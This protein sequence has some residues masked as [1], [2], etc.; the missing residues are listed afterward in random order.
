M[1]LLP[2]LA[3]FSTTLAMSQGET[4]WRFLTLTMRPVL[5]AASEQIGLASEEGG[6]LQDVADFGGGSGLGEV[7]G[8]R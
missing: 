5:P 4:N 8:C 2:V 3:I 7:H 1:F 6:D